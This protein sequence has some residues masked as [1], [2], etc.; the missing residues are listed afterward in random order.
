MVALILGIVF[1]LFAAYS[2]LPYS[3]ALNWWQPVLEV[4]KGGL[5][6]LAVF[7]GFIAV[8]IG[9]ADIKDKIETKKEE[10][11]GAESLAEN[12]EEPE[13]PGSE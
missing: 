8:F 5:P 6:I 7:V 1:I 3:W 4:L 11:E 2:V 12:S 13:D 10:A 9:I